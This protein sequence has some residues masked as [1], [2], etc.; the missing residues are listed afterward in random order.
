VLPI[1]TLIGFAIHEAFAYLS[2]VGGLPKFPG[3]H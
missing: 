2:R 3:L 1:C